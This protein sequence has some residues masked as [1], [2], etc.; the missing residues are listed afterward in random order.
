LYKARNVAPSARQ[1]LRKASR[2]TTPRRTQPRTSFPIEVRSRPGHGTTFRI[3]LRV[4]E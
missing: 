4:A 1:Q 3:S 2:R